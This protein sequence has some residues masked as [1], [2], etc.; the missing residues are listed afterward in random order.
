MGTLSRII[1]LVLLFL[2]RLLV[3]L[4]YLFFLIQI[5]HLNSETEQCETC[6][7]DRSSFYQ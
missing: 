4:N 3:V 5:H 1:P 7:L 6:Y 2:S